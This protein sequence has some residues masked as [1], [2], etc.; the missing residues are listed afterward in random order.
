MA[1][2]PRMRSMMGFMTI[3]FYVFVGTIAWPKAKW[4]A[5]IFAALG[6]IRLVLLIR[7]WPQRDTEP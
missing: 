5:G 3:A 7:Q 4:L 6:L 2:S 1:F